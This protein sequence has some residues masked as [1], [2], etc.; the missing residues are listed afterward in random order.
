MADIPDEILPKHVERVHVVALR[1]NQLPDAVV[2]LLLRLE[3]G[4]QLVPELLLSLAG[5]ASATPEETQ[6]WKSFGFLNEIAQC[7][8]TYNFRICLLIHCYSGA[9]S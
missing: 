3:V 7:R 5:A 6:I 8:I 2:P 1:L 9:V 4:Q